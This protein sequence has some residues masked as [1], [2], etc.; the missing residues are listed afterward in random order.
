MPMVLNIGTY[1]FLMSSQDHRYFYPCH[2]TAYLLI[3]ILGAE[4]IKD[5]KIEKKK[6]ERKYSDN[7]KTL[8]I[9]PAYNEEG[10]IKM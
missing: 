1:V 7:P 8:V 4:F 5:K 3:A 10:A 9:I 2:I 6:L